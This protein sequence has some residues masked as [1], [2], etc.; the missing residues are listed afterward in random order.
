VE[1]VL[2]RIRIPTV[3]PAHFPSV[4]GD[5]GSVERRLA[6]RYPVELSVRFRSLSPRSQFSGVGRV[7]NASRGGVLVASENQVALDALVEMLL[8]WPCLLDGR[9]PLQLFAAGRIIRRGASDFVATIERYEF[10]TRSNS[11]LTAELF[12]TRGC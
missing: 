9:I 2:S 6:A 1:V 5:L 12:A 3:S 8:E 4:L 7:V 10:R 11:S